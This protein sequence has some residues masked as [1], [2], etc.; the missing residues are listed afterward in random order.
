MT[1]WRPAF[2]GH[3]RSLEPTCIDRVPMTSKFLLVIYSNHGRAW[4]DLVARTLFE[5]NLSFWQKIANSSTPREFNAPLK[6]FPSISLK[7]F[8]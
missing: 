6:Y 1:P 4:A 5:I 8:D 7:A 2:Q 3:S